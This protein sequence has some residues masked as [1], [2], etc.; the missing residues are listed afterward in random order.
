MTKISIPILLTIVL[1]SG[2]VSVPTY[3]V[4]LP[5][6]DVTNKTTLGDE[7]GKVQKVSLGETMYRD[8]DVGQTSSIE[9]KSSIDSSIP[10]SMGL[11]FS[12]SI[13]PS[14]LQ[15]DYLTKHYIYY[16]TTLDNSTATH[17][18]LGK[19]VKAGDKIGIRANR[20]T[21]GLEW[22]VDNSR[23]N[24]MNPHT[25]IWSR[26]IRVS[27]Q[28]VIVPRND[29]SVFLPGTES[30]Y[31]EITYGGHLNGNYMISFREVN[32]GREYEKDFVIPKSESGNTLLSIKG[33]IIEIIEHDNLGVTF[34]IKK[35]F[36]DSFK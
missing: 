28:V 15:P 6:S 35:G 8:G 26:P 16:A 10:G 36:N 30:R 24:G 7:L 31:R 32:T 33:S 1:S 22:Y 5:Q 34:S 27:D 25:V 9:L 21:N 17:S 23:F 3:E 2:C 12:F 4:F 29:L 11:P 20:L 19:V 13:K 18:M 14:I